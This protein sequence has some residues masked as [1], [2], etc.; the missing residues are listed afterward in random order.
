M[1]RGLSLGAVHDAQVCDGERVGRRRRFRPPEKEEDAVDV[2]LVVDV[3][4]P[5][6]RSLEYNFASRHQT[7]LALV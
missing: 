7:F 3:G 4:R 2:G 1:R 6:V 5:T